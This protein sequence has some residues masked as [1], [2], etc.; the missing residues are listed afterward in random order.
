LLASFLPVC[1]GLVTVRVLRVFRF[2]SGT[3]A[4][5]HLAPG[6]IRPERRAQPLLAF[7]SGFSTAFA[8]VLPGHVPSVSQVSQSVQFGLA[9]LRISD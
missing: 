8:T 1:A 9:P 4:R 2:Q 5:L 6:K 7:R 3:R